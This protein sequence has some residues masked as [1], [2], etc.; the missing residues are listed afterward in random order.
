MEKYFSH[1]QYVLYRS[2][3]W[4]FQQKSVD[5]DMEEIPE[6]DA[7]ELLQLVGRG[8][9]TFEE[10]VVILLA[11]MP[12]LCPQLL[13]I[14]FINNKE[15]DRPYTEFGGWKGL[16]HGGF[17]PTGETAAFILAGDDWEKRKAVVQLFGK[18]HW[19]WK[20]NILRLEGQGEGEPFLSGQLRVSEEVL[21]RVFYDRDYKPDYNPGFP[22]KRI[23]TALEWDDLVVDYHVLTDLEEICTWVNHQHVIMKEWGLQRFLK[24]GYRA[25]FYG[26]PG[27][28]KTLAATL[29]GKKNGIDVYRIDLSMVVSKYIGETEK[30]LAKVFDLAENRNWILFFDEADALFGKRTTTNS[31]NDRHANQE[32][33][34]LLQRIEDFPGTVILATNLLSNID[35][36]FLR[37]FQSVIYF[38]VPDQDLRLELWKK[39]LPEKW[40]GNKTEEMS[41]EV[42]RYELSGGSM[43]NVIR[44]CA[45]QMLANQEETLGQ[46]MLV[47]AVNKELHKEKMI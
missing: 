43:A 33:A 15:L 5:Q 34:Y 45:L 30:N 35:E 24:P 25:L 37:R 29:I 9:I 20:N 31:S 14:F 21:S 42:A 39:M 7:G 2:L 46:E 38:P 40:L 41:R 16:S 26:P 44:R 12:Y 36:A 23:T 32:V 8:Q 3:S 22:A 17:L 18:E 10:R 1:F 13:D 27:T 47:Q 11:L 4:Y 28:G 6:P 19:F